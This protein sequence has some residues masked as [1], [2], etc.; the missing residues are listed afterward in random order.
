MTNEHDTSNADVPSGAMYLDPATIDPEHPG[1]IYNRDLYVMRGVDGIASGEQ[2][3]G[4]D[5]AALA[6][7]SP[8]LMVAEVEGRIAQLE[9][10]LAAT[11]GFDPISGNPVPVVQGTARVNAERELAV[12]KHSTLPYTKMRGAEIA[13]AKAT[14]PTTADKL[15]A[16]AD[17]KE[18]VRARAEELAL[19]AEA[20]ELAERLRAS[21]RAQSMGG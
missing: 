2:A 5:D 18:R 16:E 8:E 3:P 7:A 6:A 10:Q 14:L 17:H 1:A 19:E 20:K 21:K 9:R 15:Q 11:D 13:A 4:M 12:L